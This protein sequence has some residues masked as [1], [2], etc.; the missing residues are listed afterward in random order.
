MS[1]KRKKRLS[2]TIISLLVL[3]LAGAIPA[4]LIAERPAEAMTAGEWDNV[5]IAINAFIT[6]QWSATDDGEAGFLV[7]ATTLRGRL[8]SDGDNNILD[9]GDNI[10]NAPVLVDMNSA[11]TSWIPGTSIRMA[12]TAAANGTNAPAV[13]ALVEKHR[14]AGIVTD[15][16]SYCVTGHTQSPPVMAYGAMSAADYFDTLPGDANPKSLGLKWGRAGWG[17]APPTGQPAYPYGGTN[18]NFG[19]SAMVTP[20]PFALATTSDCTG[21]SAAETVRCRADVAL[22]AAVGGGQDPW[23]VASDALYQPVDIRGTPIDSYINDNAAVPAGGNPY[24]YNVPFQTMFSSSNIYENLKKLDPGAGKTIIFISRSQHN[25]GLATQGTRMLG[26]TSKALRWGLPAWNA[27]NP[28]N[29]AE[30]WT[31][32]P[33]YAFT[34]TAPDTAAP[35]IQTTPTPSVTSSSATIP[36]TTDEPGTSKVVV[37]TA[38]G[39]PYNVPVPAHDTVLHASHNVNVTGLTP[40]TTYYYKVYSYDG[41]A[42]EVVS[43]ELSFTTAGINDR[44][45]YLPWYDSMTAWGMRAWICIA[46]MT[47]GAINNVEVNVGGISRGTYNIPAGGH[48]ELK[49]DDVYGGPAYVRI[50]DGLTSGAKLTV[51]ERTLYLNSFNEN[52]A[53]DKVNAGSSFAFPW[54]DNNASWGMMGDWIGI[55]NV[56]STSATVDVFINDMVTPAITKTVA[57]GAVEIFQMPTTITNGP[58]KVVAQGGKQIITSQRVLFQQSFNEIMGDKLA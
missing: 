34:A 58:V 1:K 29:W 49:Y 20:G 39:G 22:A 17:G 25:A 2:M 31:S 9:E 18:R 14:T 19:T 47:G 13:K 8:D 16:V 48:L 56:D 37:G 46:N 36:W 43:G 3:A 5:A 55:V 42:N 15:I 33:G 12:Y 57:P 35:V 53:I 45:Y 7:D 44:Y 32:N 21:L 6:S 51:S 40:S 54:Y 50:P 52:L 41:Q 23:A 30:R 27:N 24:T 11:G 4:I 38:P 28:P 10:A 26:Y